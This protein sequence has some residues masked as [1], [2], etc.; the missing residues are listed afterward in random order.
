M[1]KQPQGMLVLVGI[2]AEE[3]SAAIDRLNAKERVGDITAEALARELGRLSPDKVQ[4]YPFKESEKS[5]SENKTTAYKVLEAIDGNDKRFPFVELWTSA[6]PREDSRF[7]GRI[8]DKEHARF[9][10]ASPLMYQALEQ[11][12]EWLMEFPYP[13]DVDGY[14][15]IAGTVR[16]ALM[17]AV[18]RNDD[19]EEGTQ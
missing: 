4:W 2:T 16:L 1:S 13:D 14:Y 7:V 9:V 10:A 8:Y 11:V 5:M 17:E 15:D 6:T 12:F 18:E 3:V 19:D